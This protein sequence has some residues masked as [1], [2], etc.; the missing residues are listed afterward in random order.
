MKHHLIPYAVNDAAFN[1]T[2]LNAAFINTFGYTLK[3][4][5]VL[6][7]WWP[8]AYPD[9][10]Y[11]KYIT[12]TWL[13]HLTEAEREHKTFEPVEAEICCKNG[14]RKQSW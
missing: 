2:Y 8:K 11:R 9:P 10:E 1:V 13:Q 4:I 7:D 12:E 5:P 6:D 3:D 14:E